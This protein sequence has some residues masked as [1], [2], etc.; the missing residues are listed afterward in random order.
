MDK[1]KRKALEKELDNQLHH[2]YRELIEE[3]GANLSFFNLLGE[4]HTP[5]TIFGRLTIAAEYAG[6]DGDIWTDSICETIVNFSDGVL[7][8]LVEHIKTL[9]PERI[10]EIQSSIRQEQ[11]ELERQNKEYKDKQ[12]EFKKAFRNNDAKLPADLFRSVSKTLMEIRDLVGQVEVNPMPVLSYTRTLKV[13]EC[14]TSLTMASGFIEG[15][16]GGTEPR[17]KEGL[18]TWR[19]LAELHLVVKD[20]ENRVWKLIYSSRVP[21]RW[22]P[23]HN[24]SPVIRSVIVDNRIEVY[25]NIELTLYSG[26]S[27]VLPMEFVMLDNVS[28]NSFFRIKSQ[29]EGAMIRPLNEQRSLASNLHL[30]LFKTVKVSPDQLIVTLTAEENLEILQVNQIPPGTV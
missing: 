23:T 5:Q 13:S 12:E 9:T 16:L 24:E 29:L 4:I 14:L 30:T 22:E 7:V 10:K 27:Y 17:N 11:E 20:L 26:I 18:T 15:L 1:K 2:L 21:V 3:T 8:D 19:R 25:A 6:T 28:M